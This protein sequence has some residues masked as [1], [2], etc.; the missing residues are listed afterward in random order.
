[1]QKKLNLVLPPYPSCFDSNS[2]CD[3]HARAPGNS[4]EECKEL[5]NRVQ[6]LIDSKVISFT[7]QGPNIN[8]NHIPGH[9]GPSINVMEKVVENRC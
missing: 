3:F 7:P 8:N 5:K 6:D 4:T 1:M 9:A 2:I